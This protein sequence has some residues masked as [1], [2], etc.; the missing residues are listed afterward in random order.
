[1]ISRT[2]SP[3]AT[4]ISRRPPGEVDAGPHGG[5]DGVGAVDDEGE[6]ERQAAGAPGE[7]EREVGRVDVLVAERFEVAG[8]LAVGPRRERRPAVQRGRRSRAARTATCAGRSRSSRIA[9]HRAKSSAHSG[10]HSAAP[11]YAASTWSHTPASAQTS[12]TASSS[13]TAPVLVAPALATTAQHRRPV[14]ARRAARRRSAGRARRRRP[15]RR[16]RRGGRPPCAP[17]SGPMR[18]TRSPPDARRPCA[19]RHTSRA[20]ASARGC[21]PSHR[22]RSTRPRSAGSPASSRSQSSAAFSAATAA[23]ASC[24]L[25]PENDHA[26]TRASNSAAVVAGAAG[27]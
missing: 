2:G 3:I 6:P 5:G 9:R 22:R 11:P 4:T 12:A 21:R 27:M 7:V 18:R 17:T 24:Q 1:M 23:P 26:P 8:G 10:R 13:S 15:R 20:T 19:A 16:R 25:S 14:D